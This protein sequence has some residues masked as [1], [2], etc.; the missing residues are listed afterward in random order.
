MLLANSNFIFWTVVITQIITS[1][2]LMTLG[3]QFFYLKRLMISDDSESLRKEIKCISLYTFLSYLFL[4]CMFLLGYFYNTPFL[5]YSERITFL[6]ANSTL[7]IISFL[8]NFIAIGEKYTINEEDF[9]PKDFKRKLILY[10][11]ISFSLTTGTYLIIL[12]LN[13]YGKTI[14][15]IATLWSNPTKIQGHL[16]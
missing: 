16:W 4:W 14:K 6:Q 9:D 2:F 7:L 12:M 1:C 11:F 3:D 8:L 5:E 10:N 15:L 13:W